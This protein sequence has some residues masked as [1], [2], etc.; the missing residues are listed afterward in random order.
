[1]DYLN[2]IKMA[3]NAR[4][5]AYAVYSK[6]KVGSAL[7]TEN[8]EVFSGCN[9]ENAS[10]SLTNCAERT[11]FFKAVSQGHTKFKAIAIVGGTID[12]LSPCFPCGACLQVISEFCDNDFK[13]I[14][15]NKNDILVYNLVDFL[16]QQFK[17]KF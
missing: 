10:F 15:Q 5:N 1:M 3:Q 9:I 17:L 16:P 8:D 12:T 4:L 2:L 13:I 14:L 7:L 11:S 6:F